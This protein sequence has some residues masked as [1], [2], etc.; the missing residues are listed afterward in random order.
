[1]LKERVATIQCFENKTKAVYHLVRCSAPETDFWL[2]TIENDKEIIKAIEVEA[3]ET[4]VYTVSKIEVEKYLE[5]IENYSSCLILYEIEYLHKEQLEK[6]AGFQT[7]REWYEEFLQYVNN[8]DILK[9]LSKDF[10]QGF[11]KAYRKFHKDNENFRQLL[12]IE[13]YILSNYFSDILSYVKQVIDNGR[14]KDYVERLYGKEFM[15]W[16]CKIASNFRTVV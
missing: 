8:D 14:P 7:L 5:T 4:N 2:Y 3:I 1:M 12:S 16:L 15:D 11:W 6:R 13:R 9:L 10:V